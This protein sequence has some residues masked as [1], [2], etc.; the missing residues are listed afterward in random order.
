M[1]AILF[2][3]LGA[4]S[5]LLGAAMVIGAVVAEPTSSQDRTIA[6][7]PPPL[8][9]RGEVVEQRLC[10][11]DGE[12]WTQRFTVRLILENRGSTVLTV[13]TAN[14][15]HGSV[16]IAA[17]SSDFQTGKYESRIDFQW[18]T[19]D[20]KIAPP[21]KNVV[22]LQPGEARA[23]PFTSSVTVIAR[24]D[25]SPVKGIAGPGKHVLSFYW[26][27]LCLGRS[28]NARWV[29][30]HKLVGAVWTDTILVEPIPIV[31]PEKPKLESCT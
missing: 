25:G 23:L 2:L 21:P 29:K 28:E 4:S 26:C 27:P 17:S 3:R 11:G 30:K 19:A 7:P 8:V 9:V 5:W 22:V 13:P 18:I 12:L 16:L 24:I 10:E 15:V 6:P 31:I 1:S 14:S 20:G